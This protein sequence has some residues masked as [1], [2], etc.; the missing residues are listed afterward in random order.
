MFL[1]FMFVTK[2]L[3]VAKNDFLVVYFADLVHHLDT[4]EIIHKKH[5]PNSLEF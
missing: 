4:I 5:F 3:L 2:I 1:Q